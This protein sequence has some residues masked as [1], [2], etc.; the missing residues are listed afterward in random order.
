MLNP[1]ITTYS[2]FSYCEKFVLYLASSS[3]HDLSMLLYSGYQA[4]FKME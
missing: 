4:A 3:V 1:M 2:S